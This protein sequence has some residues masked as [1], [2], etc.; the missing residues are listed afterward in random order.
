MILEPIKST[1]R[2]RPAPPTY[3][4][5]QLSPHFDCIRNILV[6]PIQVTT[7][8]HD[9]P[10]HMHTCTYSADDA[11]THCRV[12]SENLARCMERPRDFTGTHVC[13]ETCMHMYIHM[14]T[15]C[16]HLHYLI[17][18]VL[19]L[20]VPIRPQDKVLTASHL[21]LQGTLQCMQECS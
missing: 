13:D 3:P 21:L 5:V 12:I 16:H 18:D 1:Q 4:Q 9:G 20:P 7:G 8:V 14:C 6:E 10:V 11:L 2:Y 17:C 15:F 19:S